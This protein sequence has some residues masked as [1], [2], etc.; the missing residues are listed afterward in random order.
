MK[1]R[2]RTKVG[3]AAVTVVAVV[4]MLVSG[5]IAA[6][7]TVNVPATR[8]AQPTADHRWGIA[9]NATN[10]PSQGTVIPSRTF[11]GQGFTYG[12]WTGDHQTFAIGANNTSAT[13]TPRELS[14]GEPFVYNSGT[15]QRLAFPYYTFSLTDPRAGATSPQV[16]I[17]P[18]NQQIGVSTGNVWC[19]S[20]EWALSSTF[21]KLNP[22]WIVSGALGANVKDAILLNNALTTG[23]IASTCPFIQM[24]RYNLC[25]YATTAAT[26]YTCTDVTWTAESAF[27]KKT[28]QWDNLT[29]A[30]CSTPAGAATSVDCQYV[31]GVTDPTDF[32]QVCL[33]DSQGRT[34]PTAVWLDFSWLP[35]FAGFYNECLFKP[36]GGVDRL[37]LI[38][39]ALTTGNAASWTTPF[40]NASES[41]G[42]LT[43]SCG[44][45]VNGAGTPFGATFL[46]DTCSWTWASPGKEFAR[47]YI[48]AA[49]GLLVL[50]KATGWITSMFSAPNPANRSIGDDGD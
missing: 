29:Q 6:N 8:T 16:Y 23:Q 49:S 21:T 3:L 22:A 26:V 11:T 4:G 35:A 5:G 9:W 7:A 37:G 28:Y 19:S 46:I 10:F 41:F 14:I 20:T 44:V 13:V 43:E 39:T 45:I 25:I 40:T 42:A 27:A 30:L 34:A 12:G 50:I 33:K 18:V 36:R 17:G 2:T 15:G 48:L 24:I 47:I 38:N 31:V 1:I 32:N